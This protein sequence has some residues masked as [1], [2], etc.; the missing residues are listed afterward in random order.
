M[1][2]ITS[3]HL[4]SHREHILLNF[5]QQLSIVIT[6][7]DLLTVFVKLFKL[8]VVIYLPELVLNKHIKLKQRIDVCNNQGPLLISSSADEVV[9]FGEE[10]DKRNDPSHLFLNPTLTILISSR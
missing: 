9:L 10:V 1:I 7:L 5:D 8:I 6:D 3:Y 4:C 2:S